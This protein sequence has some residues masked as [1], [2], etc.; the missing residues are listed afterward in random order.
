MSGPFSVEGK[1][2]VITGGA[3]GIGWAIAHELIARGARVV[4]TDPG[5]TIAGENPDAES[6]REAA[7]A[8]GVG[9]LALPE[10][11]SA[12]GAA[13]AAVE[14]AVERFGALDI[15][16]N[17]AAVLRDGFIFKAQRS[18]WERVIQTN[19]TG[20][21]ALLAAA[22][23]LMREAVKGGGAPGRIVNIISTAGLY[24]NYGQ[25]AYAAAKAGLVGLTRA[26]ALDLARS[27]VNC[28]A[29]APFAATRVTESIQPANEAQ[30]AYQRRALK[31]PADYVARL[32][33]WLCS[34]G[35]DITGQIFGV[36]G[37][38]VFLFSQPR[39]AV[40]IVTAPLADLTAESLDAAISTAVRDRLV[41]LTTDLES[42]NT[43][44][45][46]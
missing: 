37:R 15:V 9:A 19:L 38:E 16:V 3:R 33:G 46:V 36:R 35:C 12:P 10:D 27:K 23:P 14:L 39:P 34:P 30:R 41:D 25:A 24:G 2:A 29:V 4:I 20:A 21:W 18:D 22:T 40:R 17:N 1:V 13:Q 11:I 8:L 6:V 42:F 26:V 43:E 7:R 44:P 5:V 31:V 32:V 45:I 28:N